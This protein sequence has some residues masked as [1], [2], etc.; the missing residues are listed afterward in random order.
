[1]V[2]EQDNK[3][4]VAKEQAKKGKDDIERLKEKSDVELRLQKKKMKMFVNIP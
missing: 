4:A 3:L 1:M 2:A